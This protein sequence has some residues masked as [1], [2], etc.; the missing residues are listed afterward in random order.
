MEVIEYEQKYE[1]IAGKLYGYCLAKAVSGDK[2]SI[3]EIN[4]L[5]PEMQLQIIVPRGSDEC[6]TGN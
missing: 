5:V 3:E 2:I 6:L 1:L 4:R